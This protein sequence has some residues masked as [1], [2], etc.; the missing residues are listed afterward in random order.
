MDDVNLI[1]ILMEPIDV[2]RRLTPNVVICATMCEDRDDENTE[3]SER[4]ER[5]EP[6]RM[7]EQSHGRV[8]GPIVDFCFP[9]EYSVVDSDANSGTNLE[10][11]QHARPNTFEQNP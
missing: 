6:S 1:T 3:V 9:L 7:H 8:D 11:A 5:V 2:V 10:K 4:S